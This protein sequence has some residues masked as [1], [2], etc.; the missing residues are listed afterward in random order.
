MQSVSRRRMLA[1]LLAATAVSPAKAAEPIITPLSPSATSRTRYARFANPGPRGYP[2]QPVHIEPVPGLR[3]VAYMPPQAREARV[4]IFSHG[5][6]ALPNVYSNLLAHWAS[7]GFAVL[8]PIHDDSVIENGLRARR[9]NA[10][11]GVSWDL[12]SLVADA[13][14]WRL[15]ARLCRAVLDVVPSLEKSSGVRLLTDRPII[16]GHSYGAYTAQLLLG[17]KAVSE[18]G[19]ALEE[20]EPRFYA[21]MLLS[22]QGRGMM[23]LVD[24]SWDSLSRPFLLATGQG[25]S[26]Q[27]PSVKIEPFALS[28]AGNKHLAWFSRITPTLYSGQQ[29]RPGT[30][31]ELIFQDLLAVTTAFLVAYADYHPEV[32][33]ELS[34]DYYARLSERR[35]DMRYR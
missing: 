27:D 28:P 17:A 26:G 15:R 2:Q 10:Q 31:D 35:L 9:Q 3:L 32:F 13:E 7:H 21:G 20:A 1:A 12:D 5:E 23:G 25:D 18:T 30:A 6:L 34:G 29:V 8:A 16:A 19:E 33:A 22:S 14:A 4:V 24:G 11:L